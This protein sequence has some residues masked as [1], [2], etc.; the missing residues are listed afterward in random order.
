MKLGTDADGKTTLHKLKDMSKRYKSSH[1]RN[2][3][4]AGVLVAPGIKRDGKVFPVP[5]AEMDKHRLNVYDEI[6]DTE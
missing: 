6:I 2:L 5:E 3:V 1:G 4:H